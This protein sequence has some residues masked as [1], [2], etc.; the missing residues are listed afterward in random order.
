MILISSDSSSKR[1]SN[2][3]SN[4]KTSKLKVNKRKVNDRDDGVYDTERT[5]PPPN[6][7]NMLLDSFDKKEYVIY[8]ILF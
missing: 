3:G 1:S 2:P 7:L 6:R 5:K 8:V 4:Q